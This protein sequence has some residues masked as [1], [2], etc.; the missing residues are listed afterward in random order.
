M[1]RAKAKQEK[2]RYIIRQALRDWYG[3]E[4]ARTEMAAYPGDGQKLASFV[5]KV[6][7]KMAGQDTLSLMNLKE[8]WDEVAGLQISKICRPV[9]IKD[10]LI[11]VEVDHNLWLR[12]LMGPTKDL[13][14]KNINNACGKDFCSDI[15]FIMPG[16]TPESGYTRR[17]SR[18]KA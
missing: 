7:S 12:E 4:F 3:P 15:R 11:T 14:I 2:Q 8:K 10:Q 18:P 13:L 17:K 9:S 16:S 5:D 1:S 6:M